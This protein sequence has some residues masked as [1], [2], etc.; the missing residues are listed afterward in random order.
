MP[1]PVAIPG[2]E[3]AAQ[4][5]LYATRSVVMIEGQPAIEIRSNPLLISLY[6]TT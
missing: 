2:G 4:G 3:N 1:L 6:R 5:L